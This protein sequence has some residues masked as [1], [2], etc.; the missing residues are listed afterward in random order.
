MTINR[1]VKIVLF[2][3]LLQF[4]IQIIFAMIVMF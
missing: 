4:V 2:I 3:I 1:V